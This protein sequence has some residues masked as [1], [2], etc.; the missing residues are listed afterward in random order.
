[1]AAPSFKAPIYAEILNL[2]A[3]PHFK[4]DGTTKD[5][6]GCGMIQKPYRAI[7]SLVTGTS[8]MIDLL[9]FMNG[10]SQTTADLAAVIITGW[11]LT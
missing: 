2:M 10:F 8:I 1:M 9:R 11:F 5:W 7:G 6:K 4:Q 3:A